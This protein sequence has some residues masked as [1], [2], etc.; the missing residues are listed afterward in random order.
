[1]TAAMATEAAAP[2]PSPTK[3]PARTAGASRASEACRK[4]F[5]GD[6]AVLLAELVWCVRK[7]VVA[8]C[9]VA[10]TTAA[11]AVLKAV[12]LQASALRRL[13]LSDEIGL[14]SLHASHA[15]FSIKG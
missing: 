2:R 12:A 11:A 7:A 9:A 3:E 13:V 10:A 5:G 14:G 4:R 8:P 15:L 1:M 6:L